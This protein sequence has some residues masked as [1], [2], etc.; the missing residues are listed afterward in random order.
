MH[1]LDY[2][3]LLF[4]VLMSSPE[5]LNRCICTFGFGDIFVGG[6]SDCGLGIEFAEDN[7]VHAVFVGGETQTGV[8]VAVVVP[9]LPT[10]Y[11]Q[12]EIQQI[13]ADGTQNIRVAIPA[14]R[15]PDL[16]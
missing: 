11:R 14:T 7:A 6:D 1:C 12:L 15:P 5:Y 16:P 10:E 2:W 13:D 8:L 4:A 3:N 9:L